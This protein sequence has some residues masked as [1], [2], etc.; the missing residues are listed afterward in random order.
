[1]RNFVSDLRLG[2]RLLLRNPGF[3]AT[4]ILLLAQGVAPRV[5]ME[6]LSHSSFALTMDPYTH[7]MAPLMRGM[8]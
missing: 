1:M 2:L 4:A 8:A 5:V 6:V 3:A 7:V